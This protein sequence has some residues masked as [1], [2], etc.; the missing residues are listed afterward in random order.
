MTQ[1]HIGR[2]TFLGYG[3]LA[4]AGLLVDGFGHPLLAQDS[5]GLAMSAPVATAHGRV[6]GL[7]RYGVNQ[8]YGVPYGASTAG[9]NRF[10]P[11][12]KPA[13][14]TGVRDCFQV[15]NRAPQDPDGPISE[16]FAMD[17]REP[18][19]E[20]CLAI[21][22][23]TP[24]LGAG[25]RPVMVWLHGGGFSGGSGN[26]LLY[27]GTNLARKE[28]VVV[29]SVNHRLNLFGFLHLAG[30]GAGE[31]WNQASNAGMLDIV[32]ALA[33]VKENIAAFGGN[34][35]NVTVFGQSGGGGKV[36]TLMAM[37]AA[38]GLFHRAI[39]QSGSALRGTTRE[40]ATK[41]AEQFLAKLGLK[42]NQLDQLQQLPWQKVQEAYFAEPR[43]QGLGNGPVV[44]GGTLPRDQ[45][46]PD[47]P[48]FSSDVPLMVG[49]VQTEDAWNDP[50]PPLQMPE[51]EMMTR[52]KRIVRNDDAKARELVALYRGKHA[53]I[54]N[55][56][57]WLIMNADNTPPRQR[58]AA[59]RAE[60]GAGQG[61][62][63]SLLLHLAVARAPGPDEVVPHARHPVR[64]RQ[65]GRGR[66]DDRLDEQP[67]R[68]RASDER[69]VGGVCPHRQPEPQG[70]AAV[71]GVQ[72]LQL[73]DDDPERRVQGGER[74]EQG[75]AA[76]AED[77]PRRRHGDRR[78]LTRPRGY[79]AGPGGR[80]S[81]K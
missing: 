49:S 36:T 21:N 48:A 24:G 75:R 80:C 67:L 50:P 15:A 74:P 28:D 45:W 22:V 12:V 9:A 33:W 40:N 38:K 69:G 56:D 20:D 66:V 78:R 63:L 79:C 7:V 23:F 16:V 81:T 39:A 34:P 8:F 6:R 14:W 5:R 11:P 4:A 60:D 65:R 37:P 59:Q 32:A 47:A 18:M 71:A 31:K 54:T 35:N 55:T 76:G 2:R 29:V 10:M 25:N 53:G 62:R 19:G 46:T 44:D 73:P 1:W 43:I 72:R 17:R 30:L 26:W 27:D 70:P 51:D 52:V 77:D 41:G 61:A 58:A 13:A 42:P 68:A 57:V 3:S 64:V